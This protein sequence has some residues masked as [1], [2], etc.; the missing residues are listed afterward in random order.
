MRIEAEGVAKKDPAAFWD[1]WRVQ[2]PS[3][4]C[5]AVLDW[6]EEMTVKSSMMAESSLYGIA[7]ELGILEDK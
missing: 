6:L 3:C 2:C 7:R 4:G 1:G 5:V